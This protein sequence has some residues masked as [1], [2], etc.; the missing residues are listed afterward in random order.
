MI[1]V[2]VVEATAI[3]KVALPSLRALEIR[4]AAMSPSFL[5]AGYRAV[6]DVLATACSATSNMTECGGGRN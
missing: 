1:V 2:A 5:A 4:V 3:I 6:N